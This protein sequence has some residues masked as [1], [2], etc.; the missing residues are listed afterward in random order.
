MREEPRRYAILRYSQGPAGT[1]LDG[2]DSRWRYQQKLRSR[3][4]FSSCGIPMVTELVT[5]DKG[6]LPAMAL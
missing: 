3:G 4:V 2:F 1:H 5:T 6:C